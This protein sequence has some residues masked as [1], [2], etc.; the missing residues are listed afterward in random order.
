MPLRINDIKLPLDHGDA[1]LRIAVLVKLGISE[2]DLHG[3]Q[4][5]RRAYDARKKSAIQLIYSV[6]VVATAIVE[7]EL[8]ARFAG[9]K[10]VMPCPDTTYRFVAKAGTSFP[11]VGQQ[12]PLV[13][14]FGPCGLF[15]ALV[16]A[17][18]GLKPI[19]LERGQD[20]RKRTQDTWGLWRNSTLDTE[21][22]V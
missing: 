21:S 16:L 2:H 18:M 1:D 15:T 8:L 12:R 14:G 11:D 4:V 19:V 5:V 9:S 13:I 22:N 7:Q 6:D 3:L 10:T 17:Q 20:V